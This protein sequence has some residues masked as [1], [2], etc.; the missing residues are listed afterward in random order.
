MSTY[1]YIHDVKAKIK[2]G[3]EYMY[4][5]ILVHVVHRMCPNDDSNHVY[6]WI[7]KIMVYKVVVDLTGF[8]LYVAI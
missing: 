3:T 7:L 2:V 1:K 4:M 6:A 5:N 8:N